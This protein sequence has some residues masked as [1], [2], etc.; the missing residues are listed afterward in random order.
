MGGFGSGRRRNGRPYVE[1]AFGLDIDK[2]VRDGL[3]RPGVD[4]STQLIWKNTDTGERTGSIGL[5]AWCGDAS[6]PCRLELYGSIGDAPFRQT[7]HLGATP[8]RFG[9][10]RLHAICPV[11]GRACRKLVFSARCRL[12]VSIPA[13][14]LRYMSECADA[15]D[16]LW[17]KSDRE[18]LRLRAFAKRRS[19]KRKR[20]AAEA[21]DRA[22]ARWGDMF[23]GMLQM[24]RE[25]LARA[26]IVD[27]GL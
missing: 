24:Q 21:Y 10:F 9:G 26:G 13:S 18:R 17:L 19:S 3:I 11:E 14:G 20:Q 25:R 27:D 16:R 8:C 6:G 5:L 12:W 2:L 7:I 22:A 1:A 4:R 15:L 23:E